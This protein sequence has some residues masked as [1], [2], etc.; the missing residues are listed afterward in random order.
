MSPIKHIIICLLLLAALPAVSPSGFG[1]SSRYAA[2]DYDLTTPQYT[3]DG[4]LLQVE[5]ATNACMRGDSNPIAAVGCTV[6]GEDGDEEGEAALVMATVSSPPAPSPDALVATRKDGGSELQEDADRA[7]RADRAE[8]DSSLR[9]AHQRTQF[10]IVEVPLSAS[11]SEGASSIL[12]GLSGILSDATSLLQI[13]HS[14]L[15]EEQRA[16][17]WHRLG[18]RPVG[19]HAFDVEGGGASAGRKIPQ[20]GAQSQSMASP[21]SETALRLS[22]AI[23]DECQK[24]AFGGGLRPFGASLL[25]AGVDPRGE[26]PGRVAMS[27]TH[28]NG[29][30]TSQISALEDGETKRH[31]VVV[32]GG[33]VKAQSHIKTLVDARLSELYADNAATETETAFLSQVL[34]AVISSLVEEWK[35]RGNP[36]TSSSTE[37]EKSNERKQTLPQME[38]VIVSSKRGTFRLADRDVARLM[39]SAGTYNNT[40]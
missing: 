4:R 33:S 25:L 24:H 26:C 3:P 13:V 1:P 39:S 36:I 38:V 23:A 14:Q 10:R 30:L 11:H 7:D 34:R 5:Y 28:P 15:D 37:V 18:A 40:E 35:G 16:F 22:R 29:G 6:S 20:S 8:V 19:V 9:D 17:G 21:P 27:E 31:R 32:S 12:I 2:Y